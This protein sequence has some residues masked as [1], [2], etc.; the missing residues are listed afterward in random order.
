MIFFLLG[1]ES[2]G[3]RYWPS[4]VKNLSLHHPT[5]K[6]VNCYVVV[7]ELLA[8][9]SQV[10]CINRKKTRDRI[11]KVFWLWGSKISV[12]FWNGA[13]CS[14]LLGN[15]CFSVVICFVTFQNFLNSNHLL[16]YFLY[17]ISLLFDNCDSRV[18]V[19]SK[20]EKMK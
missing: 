1:W 2:Q 16:R 19:E 8:L 6:F 17:L 10:F 12:H 5:A 13:F 18:C 20:L 9:L 7:F 15:Y 3:G 14:K 11:F 4:G